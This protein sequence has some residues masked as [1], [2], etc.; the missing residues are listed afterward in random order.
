MDSFWNLSIRVNCDSC[1]QFSTQDNQMKTAT[2]RILVF[3]LLV[4]LVGCSPSG[5]SD[6]GTNQVSCDSKVVGT[7][8]G[9]T[10]SDKTILRSDETYSY[11]GNDG[12]TAQGVASCPGDTT[13]GTILVTIESASF[14]NCLPAGV[15]RCAFS[16]P[17]DD[18]LIYNCGSGDFYYSR[19]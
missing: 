9:T 1:L 6:S 5:D 15:Y 10:I 7:W 11:V 4:V 3:L 8:N 2:N 16:L 13:S 18:T 14:G 17:N 19:E 12:C